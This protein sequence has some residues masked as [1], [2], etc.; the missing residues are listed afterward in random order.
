MGPGVPRGLCLLVDTT[1]QQSGGGKLILSIVFFISMV[2]NIVNYLK[3]SERM[4]IPTRGLLAQPYT[5]TPRTITIINTNAVHKVYY[6]H[7]WEF[8]LALVR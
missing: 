2:L 8:H 4:V 1:S 5:V 3:P 7:L 6:K